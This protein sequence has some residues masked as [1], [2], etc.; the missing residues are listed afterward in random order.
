MLFGPTLG[1]VTSFHAFKRSTGT[2][3]P[4]VD[5]ANQNRCHPERHDRVD[6]AG[7]LHVA[8]QDPKTGHQAVKHQPGN[9]HHQPGHGHGPPEHAFFS[10]VE[11]VRRHLL[12]AQHAT[13]LF[14]P[15]EVCSIGNVVFDKSGDHDQQR[16]S[17]Q[18]TDEVVHILEC[19]SQPAKQG[20]AY[21]RKQKEFAKRH[22]QAGH[23]QRH[24]SKGIGP[25]SGTLKRGETFHFLVGGVIMPERPFGEKHGGQSQ[26]RNQDQGTTVGDQPVVAGLPPCLA[27][28]G[29]A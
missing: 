25:V 8:A 13:K 1:H 21:H 24:K 4:H 10:R 2:D 20:G 22:D 11:S 14:Q 15:I 19:I 23:C 18:R 26:Q 17:K 5:M 16:D 28:I 3:G 7:N 29:Q 9:D 6:H 27:G 12:V